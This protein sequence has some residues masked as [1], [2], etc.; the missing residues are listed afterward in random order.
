[1]AARG[2]FPGSFNPP[3]VA[4]LA[5]AR[6]ARDRHGLDAVDLVVSRRSLAKEEVEHPRFDDRIEVIRRSIESHSWLDVVVTEA[7]LLVDIARGYDLLI[8]GAD[9]WAQIRELKWYDTPEARDLALA[10]L[11]PTAIVPR[12]GYTHPNDRVLDLDD[13]TL[14]SVSSTRARAGEIELMAPAARRF[15]LETG[16]WIDPA[17]YQ[18]DGTG[19]R[20]GRSGIP[21]TRPLL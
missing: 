14:A 13:S 20:T 5:I 11:P 9:K 4:H 19:E 15:A 12:H 16:A 10:E 6:A 21:P 17:R 8:V 7:Q 18:G 2:V 3:T 1:M